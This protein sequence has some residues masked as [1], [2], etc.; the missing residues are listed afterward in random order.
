MNILLTFFSLLISLSIIIPLSISLKI[1]NAFI[2]SILVVITHLMLLN[3][4]NYLDVQFDLRL[5]NKDSNYE[6]NKLINN[7]LDGDSD[8][9]DNGVNSE[10]IEKKNNNILDN[11]SSIKYSSYNDETSGPFDKLP[12]KELLSRLKYLHETSKNPKVYMDYQS[13]VTNSDKIVKRDKS[14]LSSGDPKY[15]KFSKEY[16]PQLTRNQ[17]NARDCLNH[18]FS[19]TSCFQH[20]KMFASLNNNENVNNN[21]TKSDS[22]LSRGVNKNNE[23]LII[24]EDFSVPSSLKNN[25]SMSGS[26]LKP[27][28]KN[29]PGNPDVIEKDISNYPC[30][31]C[32]F[33]LCLRDYCGHYNELLH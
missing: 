26:C 23:R 17:I 19:N 32:K 1:N 2:I 9:H 18:E 11:N 22:I 20:P 29:A 10:D 7:N 5:I 27:L 12:P 3:L 33:G 15:L 8:V 16:Y 31:G 28:F 13:F 14:S 25:L 4:L 6:L 30:R 21:N 24:R